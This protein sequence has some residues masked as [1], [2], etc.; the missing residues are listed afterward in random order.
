MGSESNHTFCDFPYILE[1][2]CQIQG[3]TLH[4]VHWLL[5]APQGLSGRI[6]RGKQPYPARLVARVDPMGDGG[7]C[8]VTEPLVC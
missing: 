6:L 4:S 1:W 2:E 5:A 7:S 8:C 3:V